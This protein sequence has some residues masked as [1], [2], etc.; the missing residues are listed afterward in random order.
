MQCIVNALDLCK[1]SMKPILTKQSCLWFVYKL[2]YSFI[3]FSCQQTGS[4]QGGTMA[5]FSSC[6]LF[7]HL[8]KKQKWWG[9]LLGFPIN[10]FTLKS[11]KMVLR[12]HWNL[13]QS[14]SLLSD[15]TVHNVMH[16][17]EKQPRMFLAGYQV[18]LGAKCVVFTHG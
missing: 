9:T 18:H 5:K 7:W 17:W 15:L 14:C 11:H 16:G 4:S 6:H 10:K 3:L 13:L 12:R 8:G 1:E 2:K